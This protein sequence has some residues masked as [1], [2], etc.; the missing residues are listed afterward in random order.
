MNATTI[1]LAV[2]VLYSMALY[3]GTDENM[4]FSTLDSNND[5][6]ISITEAEGQLGMLRKWVDIDKDVDGQLGVSE[7]SA[8]EQSEL[9]AKTY[10]PPV[11][12]DDV[13]FGAEPF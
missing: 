5:G 12:P 6:Y 9:P 7:F 3:A 2:A 4:S 1:S 10:V 13:D 8:F 11:N